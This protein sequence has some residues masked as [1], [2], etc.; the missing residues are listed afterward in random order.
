MAPPISAAIARLRPPSLRGVSSV[1]G[2]DDSP[3]P[4]KRTGESSEQTPPKPP[5]KKLPW[6]ERQQGKEEPDSGRVEHIERVTDVDGSD[7]S[8]AIQPGSSMLPLRVGTNAPG[9]RTQT[10]SPRAHS[11]VSSLRPRSVSRPART[12]EAAAPGLF[13]ASSNYS[14]APSDGEPLPITLPKKDPASY[15]RLVRRPP[16][17]PPP[18][19][20]STRAVNDWNQGEEEQSPSQAD[21]RLGS[22]AQARRGTTRPKPNPSPYRVQEIP[23]KYLPKPLRCKS[24]DSELEQAIMPTARSLYREHQIQAPKCPRTGA[25]LEASRSSGQQP[26]PE[27]PLHLMAHSTSSS[28]SNTDKQLDKLKR[29]V[30]ESFGTYEFRKRHDRLARAA[31]A[32]ERLMN[33]TVTVA[34]DSRPEG[35]KKGPGRLLQGANSA[36]DQVGRGEE[37]V[38]RPP[39]LSPPSSPRTSEGNEEVLSDPQL[40]RSRRTSANAQHSVFTKTSKPK[41]RTTATGSK[42]TEA[43]PKISSSR[44]DRTAQAFS[45]GD[46]SIAQ[47]PPHLYVSRSPQCVIK[48]FAY[49]DP[50]TKKKLSVTLDRR[51]RYGAAAD[52]YGDHGESVATQPGARRSIVAQEKQLP[53]VPLPGRRHSDV[54]PG[55]TERVHRAHHMRHEHQARALPGGG[56]GGSNQAGTTQADNLLRPPAVRQATV[57]SIH[58]PSGTIPPLLREK[59]NTEPKDPSPSPKTEGHKQLGHGSHHQGHAPAFLQSAYYRIDDES[60]RKRS[61][62]ATTINSR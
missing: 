12:E 48:D 58:G 57:E 53:M 46:Y 32:H 41:I 21:P 26:L 11:A 3:R 36:K 31:T 13:Y 62:T 37:P 59:L 61:A 43:L 29:A 22:G 24:C 49:L 40:S 16:E 2:A 38:Y 10:P 18:G 42:F 23:E 30:T 52:F 8:D 25:H 35:G 51:A 6:L 27:L 17:P 9:P 47:T 55:K 44:G 50:A 7:P 1:E 33:Q 19:H 39:P 34:S 45:S 28:Q 20:Y 5:R 56:D 15:E 14:P 54:A 60:V 4:Y